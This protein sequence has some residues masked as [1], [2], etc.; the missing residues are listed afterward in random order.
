[1]QSRYRP[2]HSQVRQIILSFSPYT[3]SRFRV[4]PPTY[5][6]HNSPLNRFRTGLLRFTVSFS[7]LPRAS[8]RSRFR[9][10]P[11]GVSGGAFQGVTQSFHS[12]K[13]QFSSSFRLLQPLSLC[14]IFSIRNVSH[15]TSHRHICV[16]RCRATCSWRLC[17][18][19]FPAQSS[20]RAFADFCR[21]S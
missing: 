21:D 1:M 4:R 18:T 19:G 9:F 20:Y 16:F 10:P 15:N 7:R 12:S 13:Y 8:D 5:Q 11:V 17:P 6:I 14:R 2:V 3:F